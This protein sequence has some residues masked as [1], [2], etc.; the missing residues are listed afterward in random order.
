[1]IEGLM[2]LERHEGGVINDRILMIRITG[3]I[4]DTW[5]TGWTRRNWCDNLS[6]TATGL[7]TLTIEKGLM[8]RGISLREL[9]WSGKFWVESHTFWPQTYL[10]DLTRCRLAARRVRALERHRADLTLLQVRLHLWMNACTEGTEDSVSWEVN[11]G[12]W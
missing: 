3:L 10:G 2:G 5:N 7:R 4:Q 11:S 9:T 12:G 1:M 6:L 8:K